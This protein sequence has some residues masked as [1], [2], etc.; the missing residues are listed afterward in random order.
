MKKYLDPE[1]D[2]YRY[3]VRECVNGFAIQVLVVPSGDN[4]PLSPQVAAQQ[5]IALPDGYR[6]QSSTLEAS[7]AELDRLAALN[8]W[9]A[10]E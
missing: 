5:Q 10:I 8:G 3:Y 1:N 7:E 9:T 6:I 2:R 4:I